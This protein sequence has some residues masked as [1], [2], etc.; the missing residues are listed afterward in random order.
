[1]A[2]QRQFAT[3]FIRRTRAMCES[4]P[5]H[6][7]TVNTVRAQDVRALT[8]AEALL[9]CPLCLF[10][11]RTD[12]IVLRFAGIPPGLV[13]LPG[14]CCIVST[15]SRASMLTYNCKRRCD[16]RT[17]VTYDIVQSSAIVE[18]WD[19]AYDRCPQKYEEKQFGRRC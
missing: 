3:R 16:V 7:M 6:C 14:L 4:H 13:E 18:A 12:A 11:A 2:T 19:D 9:S 5:K 15:Q 10:I 17:F 1:M 8:A